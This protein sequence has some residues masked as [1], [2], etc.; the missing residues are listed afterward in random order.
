MNKNIFILGAVISFFTLKLAA[1][2]AGP[3]YDKV[4]ESAEETVY[5]D[6]SSIKQFENQISVLVLIN[7]KKPQKIASINKETVSIKSQLLFN[8]VTKKYSLIG[9]LYY[10]KNLKILGETSLPGFSSGGETFSIMIE[11]NL[12]M[13]AVFNKCVEYLDSGLSPIEEKSFPKEIKKK[14]QPLTSDL[15]KV[16]KAENPESQVQ[17]TSEANDR[18]RMFLEKKD[19]VENSAIQLQTQ[20]KE[21]SEP[22]EVKSQNRSESKTPDSGSEMETNPKS[23]IFKH[24]AKYSFQISSWQNRSKAESEVNRYKRMGHNSFLAEG[25]VRG[26]TWYRVRIGYFNSIEETEEYMRKLK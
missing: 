5:I 4:L 23:T 25:L 21:T 17:D 11:G 7:Y 13:T 6:T 12:T 16:S 20:R 14:E 24:G 9:T 15:N 26:V 10:D 22:P 3:K 2:V 8:A 18:V 1:Q 19:S